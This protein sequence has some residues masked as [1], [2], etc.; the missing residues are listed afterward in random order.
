MGWGGGGERGCGAHARLDVSAVR[1]PEAASAA[2]V[3]RAGLGGGTLRLAP[4]R[5]LATAT[6]PLARGVFFSRG[7]SP[8]PSLHI[9]QIGHGTGSISVYAVPANLCQGDSLQLPKPL[10]AEPVTNL[11]RAPGALGVPILSLTLVHGETDEAARWPAAAVLLSRLHPTEFRAA[12]SAGWYSLPPHHMSAP[13]AGARGAAADAC[14][15]TSPPFSLR[16]QGSRSW[17]P[18]SSVAGRRRGSRTCCPSC[19]CSAPR[20]ARVWCPGS[21]LSKATRW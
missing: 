6:I 16:P 19:P 12:S 11:G 7:T 13:E 10:P 3:R 4:G 8:F 1:M 21:A 15:S 20:A 14:P 2:A 17:G 9:F 5:D 18:A